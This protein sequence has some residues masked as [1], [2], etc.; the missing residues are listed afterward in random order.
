MEPT[1][2]PRPRWVSV[3]A[4]AGKALSDRRA[5]AFIGRGLLANPN[6]TFDIP[7][8]HTEADVDT[9]LDIADQAF[10]APKKVR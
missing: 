10:A 4:T 9:T 2:T 7:I 8:A 5:L 6:G 1:A 3:F